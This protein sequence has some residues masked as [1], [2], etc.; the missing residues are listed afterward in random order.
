MRNQLEQIVW[1]SPTA[2]EYAKRYID[3][4][5]AMNINPHKLRTDFLVG[6]NRSV[7]NKT[8]YAGDASFMLRYN[9]REGAIACLEDRRDTLR[10]LQVKGVK[11]TKAGF[12]VGVCMRWPL[13]FGHATLWVAQHPGVN[14]RRVELPDRWDLG[15]SETI[16]DRAWRR[17]GEF[18]RGAQ[19]KYSEED[20][21]Y[22]RDIP[23]SRVI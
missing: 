8:P 20:G 1:T 6:D 17:Y 16:S 18:I 22:V 13:H 4:H 21:L 2:N 5:P 3:R 19:L 14:Y 12:I 9:G 11:K 15:G 10:V 7:V 23:R